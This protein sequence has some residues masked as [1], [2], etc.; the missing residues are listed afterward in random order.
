MSLDFS[1]SYSQLEKDSSQSVVRIERFT[2]Q[3]RNLQLGP[4]VIQATGYTY[5]Y[6]Q[7]WTDELSIE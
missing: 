4:Q 1:H 3:L 6:Y 5:I 2:L 7:S